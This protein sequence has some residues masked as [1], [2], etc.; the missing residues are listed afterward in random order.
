M[1][2]IKS[3]TAIAFAAMLAPGLANAA[4]VTFESITGAWSNATG[5][6]ATYTGNG[7]STTSARWGEPLAPNTQHSGYDFASV[8]TPLNV[9]VNPPPA[10]GLFDIGS[11]T[12]LNYSLASGTGITGIRLTLTAMIS[13]DGGAAFA[14]N[15][16]YDFVHLET[17]NY[18]NT[19]PNMICANGGANYAGVNINGCADRI[20]ILTNELTDGFNVDGVDYTLRIAGFDLGGSFVN[21]FWTAEAG[22]NTA[23]LQA[24]IVARDTVVPTPVPEPLSLAIFGTA[25]LGLGSIVYHR[26]G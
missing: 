7:T 14:K 10:T 18:S 26:R 12:H 3:L 19:D 25:L 2:E 22:S 6:P 21:E 15:F 24:D 1:I 8:S 17:P 4:V 20:T 16:V 13:V 23:R 5:N 11:F 9:A